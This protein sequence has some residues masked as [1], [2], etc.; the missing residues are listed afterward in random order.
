MSERARVA[1]LHVRSRPWWPGM[2]ERKL[3]S[4]I[5]LIHRTNITEGSWGTGA[6]KVDTNST[7]YRTYI[8][9]GAD[10]SLWMAPS[11]ALRDT[12]RRA[13]AATN[14][15]TEPSTPSRPRWPACASHLRPKITPQTRGPRAVMCATSVGAL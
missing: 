7:S 15:H 12:R 10:K 8:I 5:A 1:E 3:G 13:L 9:I 11:E 14:N 6:A 2:G 4:D